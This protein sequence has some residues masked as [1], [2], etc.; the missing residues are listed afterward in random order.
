MAWL[1]R[2][3]VLAFPA[4]AGTLLL[5]LEVRAQ[6]SDWQQD[7]SSRITAS[8]DEARG[9]LAGEQWLVY[10]NRSPDT[11]RTI[12]FHLYLNAFRP[13]SRWSGWRAS[14]GRR[15]TRRGRKRIT[16]RRSP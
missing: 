15:T 9:I 2:V 10:R 8:L 13:G 12:A 1:T 4:L 16:C 11:L 3:A 5:P 14:G 6:E 7:V